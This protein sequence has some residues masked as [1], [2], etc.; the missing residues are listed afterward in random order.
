MGHWGTLGIH[1]RVSISSCS[2]A[3]IPH[4]AAF[5]G[6]EMQ[7]GSQGRPTSG[8]SNEISPGWKAGRLQR[9]RLK[10]LCFS[11]RAVDSLSRL[12]YPLEYC[13][14]LGAVKRLKGTG[15]KHIC[16][17]SVGS[18]VWGIHLSIAEGSEQ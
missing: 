4:T 8:D 12:E 6:P 10:L 3:Y 1:A 9:V 14:R 15:Y 11:S 7:K 18:V 2:A 17:G 13:R 16:V 5:P